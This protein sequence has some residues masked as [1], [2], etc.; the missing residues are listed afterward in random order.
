MRLLK[1]I[2]CTLSSAEIVDRAGQWQ[3]IGQRYVQGITEC[4][5]GYVLTMRA[6]KRVL[7]DVQ[8]LVEAERRCCA[9]MTLDLQRGD[10]ATLR[11]TAES[12]EGVEVIKAIFGL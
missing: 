6:D 7:D 11:V 12:P 9:W 4:E 5:G 2:V 1:P 10:P 8:R 3:S